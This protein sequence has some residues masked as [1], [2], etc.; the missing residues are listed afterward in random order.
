VNI[1]DQTEVFNPGF[2]EDSAA[3]CLKE[4]RIPASVSRQTHALDSSIVPDGFKV[5]FVSARDTERTLRDP[6]NAIGRGESVDDA[7]ER[8]IAAGV[9]TL[10]EIVFNTPHTRAVMS[11]S[12][13]CGRLCGNGGAVLFVN[14]QGKWVRAKQVCGGWVS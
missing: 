4:I 10:S 12:F 14:H 5:H 8:G 7:V 6:G 9:M 3:S 13:H 2:N 11:Y 1:A